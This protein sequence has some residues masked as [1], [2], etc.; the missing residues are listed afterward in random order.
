MFEERCKCAK[1]PDQT[2]SKHASWATKSLYSLQCWI[3]NFQL[4]W[5]GE[6]VDDFG[7]LV[8]LGGLPIYF[9]SDYFSILYCLAWSTFGVESK[10]TVSA[11]AIRG[12]PRRRCILYLTPYRVSPDYGHC[13]HL[14]TGLCNAKHVRLKLLWVPWMLAHERP[15]TWIH[16]LAAVAA[17]SVEAALTSTR[18]SVEWGGQPHAP[19]GRTQVRWNSTS[20]HLESQIL[21]CSPLI[22]SEIQAFLPTFSQLVRLSHASRRTASSQV[23][24]DI[25]VCINGLVQILMQSLFL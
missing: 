2:G 24:L 23:E 11:K 13:F 6:S 20:L 14:K 10:G 16:P 19:T 7:E 22:S 18:W 17:L 12:S 1:I 4:R 3:S 5:G 8:L 21:F 9:S 25:I 15:L